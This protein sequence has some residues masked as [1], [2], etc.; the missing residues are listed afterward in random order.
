MT[1]LIFISL[2]QHDKK[3]FLFVGIYLEAAK[4]SQFF[5]IL[6]KILW[7]KI[8]NFEL[9]WIFVVQIVIILESKHDNKTYFIQDDSKKFFGFWDKNEMPRIP[10]RIQNI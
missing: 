1:W 6:R 5:G 3:S 8:W 2:L 10:I 7:T 4:L 9:N